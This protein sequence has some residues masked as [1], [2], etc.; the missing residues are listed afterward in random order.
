MRVATPYVMNGKRDLEQ[1][2][3]GTNLGVNGLMMLRTASERKK[4]GW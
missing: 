1:A 3:R 4:D 2:C